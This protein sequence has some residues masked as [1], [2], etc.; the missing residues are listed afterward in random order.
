MQKKFVGKSPNDAW[1]KTMVLSVWFSLLNPKAEVSWARRVSEGL[2]QGRAKGEQISRRLIQ[3]G[4]VW[5]KIQNEKLDMY[6]GRV[7]FVFT[8][9]ALT[10]KSAYD[11]VDRR[12]N[13][14]EE[15]EEEEEE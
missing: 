3:Y 13:E 5:I 8:T 9:Q 14:E 10:V 7:S 1:S 6:K 12:N 15:E 4:D 11:T 2:L